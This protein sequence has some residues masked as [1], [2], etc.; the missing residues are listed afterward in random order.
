MSGLTARWRQ[1]FSG[2][3]RRQLS[4]LAILLVL[5]LFLGSIASFGPAELR[6]PFWIGFMIVAVAVQV[7]ILWASRGSMMTPYG[8]AQRAF[9]AGD[10]DTA[11]NL[12]RD[13]TQQ[14]PEDVRA[15]T[16][17]GNTYR[18]LGRLEESHTILSR[19]LNIAPE[20]YFP[21]YGFGRTLLSEGLYAEAAEHI[22]RAISAG[23]PS[24]V[25][26]DFAE[27]LYHAGERQQA[28]EI[29]RDVHPNLREP[30]RQ[31]MAQHLL[32]QL[33]LDVQPEPAL[34]RDGLPYW[35]ASAERFQ[36]TPYGILLGEIV[37]MLR[38]YLKEHS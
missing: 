9:V 30:F 31:L 32:H 5:A 26:F 14:H 12:L 38:T 29:L 24:V 11:Q 35:E 22:Q 25:Q 6:N 33:N 15:L 18:Q 34:I 36:Q 28:G 16:L 10:F 3:S 19:A 2:W 13:Y 8:R 23:A 4:I 21:L 1:F 37:I 20:H 27:A 7:L 17:L